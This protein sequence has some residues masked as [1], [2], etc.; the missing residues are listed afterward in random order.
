M[1]D[2]PLLVQRY[3]EHVEEVLAHRADDKARRLLEYTRA[4]RAYLDRADAE[5]RAA[6]EWAIVYAVTIEAAT[7]HAL[8]NRIVDAHIRRVD[9]IRKTETITAADLLRVDALHKG[10]KHQAKALGI[11]VRHLRR[12]R[13]KLL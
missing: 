11:S 13:K 5:S 12:L 9:A 1:A 4:V 3:L 7:E 2:V 10:R 8:S 6:V